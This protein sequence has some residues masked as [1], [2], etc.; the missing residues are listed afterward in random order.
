MSSTERQ[1]VVQV[2]VD[3]ILIPEDRV[4]SIMDDEILE[5]LERSI[6]QH[7]ILQPL[8]LAELDGKLVLIDG[9]HRL[10]IAKKLG[11]KTVP[12]IIKPMTEDQLLVTNLI[13]N[14][15][16]GKSNPA[17][18]ARVLAKLVDEY[19]YDF[20]KA[21]SMLGMS[22]HTADRYYRIA[23]NA[24]AKTFKFLE[25]GVLSVGCAY[26]LSYIDDKQKQDEIAEYAV[27]WGY[28][29]EQCKAATMSVL[30][31]TL[32]TQWEMTITGEMKP[33]PIPVYPCGKE[34]EPSK[35]VVVTFDAEIWPQV[36]EA[37]KRLC[38]EGFFYE[39]TIEQ[40]IEQP[41]EA[42]KEQLKETKEVAI[43]QPKPKPK[44]WFIEKL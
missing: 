39:E 36:E 23:K 4:T 12:A 19:G 27:K 18:E 37:L 30:N 43:E 11:M 26:W 25:S 17:H 42:P 35:T 38:E 5:E 14:R 8:Q 9:L 13:M 41:K 7:G 16:R 24:S 29:V 34:V 28:T 2:E 10:Y 3:K 44:D 15:Q 40:P 33:K 1:E 21:A 6:R 31:P 20:D 32:P 22:R